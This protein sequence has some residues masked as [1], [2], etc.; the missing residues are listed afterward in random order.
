M[1]SS[2]EKGASSSTNCRSRKSFISAASTFFEENVDGHAASTPWTKIAY[3]IIAYFLGAGVLSL[4]FAASQLGYLLFGV[5]L[6]LVYLASLLSARAY[7][8]CYEAHPVSRALSDVAKEAYGKRAETGTRI[9]AYVFMTLVC[10]ILHL[11]C[12]ISLEHVAPGGCA[13]FYSLAVAVAIVLLLQVRDMSEI[14][15]LSIIGVITILGVVGIIVIAL[16]VRGGSGGGESFFVPQTHTTLLL[17]AIG[18][19]DVVFSFAGQVIYIELLSEME[20]PEDFSKAVFTSNTVMLCCYAVVGCLGYHIVGAKDLKS[21]EPVTSGVASRG[22][23]LDRIVNALLFVHVI[24]AYL[25]EANVV[26]RGFLLIAGKDAHTASQALWTTTTA[27]LVGF[28]FLISNLVP[29]FSAVVAFVSAFAATLVC[30]CLPCLFALK[31]DRDCAVR[32]GR[33]EKVA[34]KVLIPITIIISVV[35]TAA[36]IMEMVKQ[37]SDNAFSFCTS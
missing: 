31:L 9:L 34:M 5:A 7:A 30:W 13:V 35:G 28:A 11:T 2:G 23:P 29:F 3:I 12:S 15:T 33:W 37:G 20:K 19:M 22:S 1:A 17:M 32:L 14:G 16:P 10:V 36:A 8:A 26:A 25:I 18:F 4:P 24:I 6:V 27:L 21:G